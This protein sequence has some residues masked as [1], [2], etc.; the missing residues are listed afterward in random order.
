MGDAVKIKPTDK[1][2]DG[3]A[4]MFSILVKPIPEGDESCK[5]E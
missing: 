5:H 1:I 2:S 4:W 3:F